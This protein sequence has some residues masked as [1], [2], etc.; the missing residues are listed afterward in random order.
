MSRGKKPTLGFCL[1]NIRINAH[2]KPINWC[3]LEVK[4]TGFAC[5]L[6]STSHRSHWLLLFQSGKKWSHRL[7]LPSPSLP[8][9]N[10]QEH[11]KRLPS[12]FHSYSHSLQQAVCPVLVV[13]FLCVQPYNAPYSL[14]VLDR[15]PPM[16]GYTRTDW[17]QKLWCDR[18]A[19]SNTRN[20]ISS[21]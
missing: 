14:S 2:G 9:K 4:M 16:R 8:T 19:M 18:F 7:C 6:N 3:V 13:G 12:P 21:G 15:S 10:K 5:V 11:P 1:T 17:K 20:S